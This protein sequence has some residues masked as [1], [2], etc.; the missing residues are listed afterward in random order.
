MEEIGDKA[1]KLLEYINEK[2]EVTNDD[3]ISAFPDNPFME[4]ALLQDL[5]FVTFGASTNASYD[6]QI[7]PKGRDYLER[8]KANLKQL[9]QNAKYQ[10]NMES[11][12]RESNARVDLLNTQVD[13]IKKRMEDGDA[14]NAKEA[15]TAKALSI[16]AIGVAV[17]GVIVTIFK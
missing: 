5:R 12:L 9:E 10:Q 1:L 7:T 11:G 14:A 17:I 2:F 13:N 16:I 15:K 3:L 8:H 4:V 6:Y